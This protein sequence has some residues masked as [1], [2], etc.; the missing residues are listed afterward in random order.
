METH[1]SNALTA[2]RCLVAI[3]ST[4]LDAVLRA[5]FHKQT[6]RHKLHS[7]KW[8]HY[9]EWCVHTEGPSAAASR[10][11]L[12]AIVRAVHDKMLPLSLA[13]CQHLVMAA[14]II[15]FKSAL[16]ISCVSPEHHECLSYTCHL[17]ASTRSNQSANASFEARR[18]WHMNNVIHNC[19]IHTVWMRQSIRALATLWYCQWEMMLPYAFAEIYAK[20]ERII[21]YVRQIC[22]NDM[23][24]TPFHSEMEENSK[25]QAAD[26]KPNRITHAHLFMPTPM[27]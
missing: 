19:A 18:V 14:M 2:Y 20:H 26:N 24:S 21:G 7:I 5:A 10:W 9:Y 16:P 22:W 17:Q 12:L 15:P 4:R 3:S 1:K 11:R 23:Q 8:H 25:I 13:K 27:R 6:R